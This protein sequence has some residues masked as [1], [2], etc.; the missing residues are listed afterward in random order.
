MSRTLVTRSP[1][2]SVALIEPI[3][4]RWS[5]RAFD[6]ERTVD[7]A[8]LETLLEAARWSASAYNAQPWRFAVALRGSELFAS[9]QATLTDANQVWAPKSAAFIL[10]VADLLKPDGEPNI[11]ARYDVGQAVAHLSTQATADGLSVRQMMGFNR[12]QVVALFR[13][14][15]RFEPQ[16]IIAVGYPGD[17]EEL[18]AYQYEQEVGTRSRRPLKESLLAGPVKNLDISVQD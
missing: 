3:A 1:E 12:A 4:T 7:L 15:D 14:E 9:L 18:A 13:L 2:S 10:T 16:T 11:M 5:P 17:P 8:E 6:P